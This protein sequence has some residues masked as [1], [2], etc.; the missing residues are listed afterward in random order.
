MRKSISV[1][2]LWLLTMRVRRL[3]RWRERARRR[4]FVRFAA[5]GITMIAK[6]ILIWGYNLMTADCT[7]LPQRLLLALLVSFI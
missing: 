6:L 2:R 5:I 1:S 3:D 4:R 7:Y